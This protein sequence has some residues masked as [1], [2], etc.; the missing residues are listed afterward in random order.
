MDVL[1]GLYKYEKERSG[2]KLYYRFFFYWKG[3]DT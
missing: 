3:S 2:L 1:Q